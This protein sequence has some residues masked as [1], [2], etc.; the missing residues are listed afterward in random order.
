[1][2]KVLAWV[3]SLGFMELTFLL[4]L[5]MLA[6]PYSSGIIILDS[7]VGLFFLLMLLKQ[8][9][10]VWHKDWSGWGLLGLWTLAQGFFLG[11]EL[12]L[13]GEQWTLAV[14]EIFFIV[15]LVY[16]IFMILPH[17][18]R[19]RRITMDLIFAAVITYLL[20]AMIFGMVYDLIFLFNPQSFQVPHLTSPE[21]TF[22][23]HEFLYFSLLTI[24]TLGYGDIV[25]LLPLAQMLSVLEAVIG[26]LYVAILI[27]GLVGIH[28]SEAARGRREEPETVGETPE[29][30]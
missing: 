24:T 21:D 22:L 1:M 20:I 11:G 2:E 29:G 19:S 23:R 30:L 28:I 12:L 14:A 15:L 10:P 27:A 25:A 17:I 26:S 6:N 8:L 18:L 16:L 3:R 4:L 13:P 5:L 9:R 7:L